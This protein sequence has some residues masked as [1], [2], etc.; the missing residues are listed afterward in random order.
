MAADSTNSLMTLEHVLPDL[1]SKTAA[2][3]L[4][5]REL[6][7]YVAPALEEFRNEMASELGMDDYA[8]IDK[9]ELPSRLNGK[10]GGGM[11]KKMVSFA[12][13]VLAWN[14]KNRT[15]LNEAGDKQPEMITE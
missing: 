7:A 10:V 11:T 13:A 9:G 1:M 12:E 5:P 14:Y 4:V 6:Q 8:H 2:T 3:G 15:L